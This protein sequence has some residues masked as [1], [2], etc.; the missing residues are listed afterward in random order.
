MLALSASDTGALML[1]AY[2]LIGLIGVLLT[3]AWIMV[4]FILMRIR[5]ETTRGL[6][7][8]VKQTARGADA[9]AATLAQLHWLVKVKEAE[10]KHR[11]PRQPAGAKPQ[12]V[13]G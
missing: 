1:F 9:A 5:R 10:M 7:E 2:A 4:P 8:L 13:D 11:A 12:P 6:D 3:V